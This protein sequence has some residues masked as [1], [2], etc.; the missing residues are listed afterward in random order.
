MCLSVRYR[1]HFPV[2]QFQNQAHIRNPHDPAEVFKTMGSE[3]A[4]NMGRRR[5]PN[6]LF[7]RRRR[8]RQMGAEGTLNAASRTPFPWRVREIPPKACILRV[9]I[10]YSSNHNVPHMV[11]ILYQILNTLY[12]ICLYKRSSEIHVENSLENLISEHFTQNA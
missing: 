6:F 9:L 8:R 1:N 2:V 10:K 4:R 12:F 3:G 11:N 7:Y 5:Q